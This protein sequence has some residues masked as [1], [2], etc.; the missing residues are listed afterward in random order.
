MLCETCG[1]SLWAG[2]ACRVLPWP[3]P[4]G[5]PPV[6]AAADYA[7]QARSVLLAHKERGALPLA[8]PLGRALAVAVR[9]VLAAR[10]PVG[11]VGP[12]GVVGL[13]PV[14]SARSA[15][16]R[17]GHDP[18][19]R[20]AL[21]AASRLRRDGVAARVRPV[22]RQRRAVADQSGLSAGQRAANLTGALVAVPGSLAGAEPL[23]LVDDL[24]TTGASLAEAARAAGAAGGLVLGA[25]VVA[26]PGRLRLGRA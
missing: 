14:P 15:V 7:D 6:Y 26:A 12:V 2:P 20:I 13:V 25:A 5:L 22:L 18:V 24:V 10:P 21:A 19:R 3:P 23:V 1:H 4:A 11:R 9:G 17:R 8:A 16:A